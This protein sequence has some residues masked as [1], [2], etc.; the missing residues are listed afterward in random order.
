LS[1]LLG[2]G[3]RVNEFTQCESHYLSSAWYPEATIGTM[4]DVFCAV[5]ANQQYN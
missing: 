2:D 5:G 3:Q 4:W 1:S